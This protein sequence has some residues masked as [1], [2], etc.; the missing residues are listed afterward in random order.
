M[1]KPS[2]NNNF[3]SNS[4]NWSMKIGKKNENKGNFNCYYLVSSWLCYCF[5]FFTDITLQIYQHYDY[6]ICQV[7]FNDGEK[8][9]LLNCGEIYLTI[10]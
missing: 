2:K 6:K 1:N 10:S 7:G 8:C 9:A 3:V 4:V 5:F